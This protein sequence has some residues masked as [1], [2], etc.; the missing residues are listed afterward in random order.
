MTIIAV[1]A[2][3]S[4][5]NYPGWLLCDG[6]N[7]TP[8]PRCCFMGDCNCQFFLRNLAAGPVKSL[9]D[10]PTGVIL[11]FNGPPKEIPRGWVPK[12]NTRILKNYQHHIVR[13]PVSEASSITIGPPSNLASPPTT[14]S[15][16]VSQDGRVLSTILI[17]NPGVGKRTLLNVL[18][19]QGGDETTSVPFRSGISLGA[20][21]TIV[22]QSVKDTSGSISI[23]TPGLTDTRRQKQ[24]AEEIKKA[25]CGVESSRLS[26]SSPWNQ[27]AYD[28]LTRL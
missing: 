4:N 20:G 9:E 14:P 8:D 23:D 13:A 5:T 16:E 22:C 17:G 11:T 27:V 6:Q 7:G 26:L 1:T 18:C 2:S 25:L 15:D 21:M 10:L 24:A 3:N 28:R 19:C 12:P